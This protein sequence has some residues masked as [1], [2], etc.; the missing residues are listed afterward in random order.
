MFVIK[1][2]DC[3]L[4][5]S[6]PPYTISV[7]SMR[8]PK[9]GSNFDLTKTEIYKEILAFILKKREEYVLKRL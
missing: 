1:C 9:H 2:V 6:K 3:D 4:V 8:C 7:V 5:E